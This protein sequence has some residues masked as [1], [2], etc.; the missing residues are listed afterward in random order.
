M[1]TAK[2]EQ[3][4]LEQKERFDNEFNDFKKDVQTT[5]NA[6]AK[7]LTS[8][9]PEAL[10]SDAT[11]QVQIFRLCWQFYNFDKKWGFN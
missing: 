10:K 11:L 8:Y 7:I 2:E 6:V 1:R 5:V 9:N 3:R 4:K